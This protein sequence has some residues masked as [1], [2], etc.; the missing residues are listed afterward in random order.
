MANYT[1]TYLSESTLGTPINLVGTEE[2]DIHKPVCVSNVYDEV[3]LYAANSGVA[4]ATL[5][6][7]FSGT[8]MFNVGIP[9][10]QGLV[11]ILPGIPL[12]SGIDIGASSSSSGVIYV[13]GFVNN[14]NQTV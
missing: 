5:I 1:K 8:A 10:G 3:W 2:Y 13:T 7:Y 12:G 6:V 4:E 14:I 9:A 11:Q